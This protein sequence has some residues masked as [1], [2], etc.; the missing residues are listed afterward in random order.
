MT[1]EIGVAPIP[2]SAF[3][4]SEHIHLPANLARFCFIKTDDMLTEAAKR[5]KKI[6]C[7]INK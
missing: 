5:L 6:T 1:K 2:P 3:Y 4:S 7:K